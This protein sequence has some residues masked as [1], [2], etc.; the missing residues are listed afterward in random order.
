MEVVR[1]AVIQ[2]STMLT[3]SSLVAVEM[4]GHGELYF[5]FP[6]VLHLPLTGVITFLC[7]MHVCLVKRHCEC[8]SG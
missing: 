2:E 3:W 7:V 6:P 4:M 1:P 5:V 8:Q